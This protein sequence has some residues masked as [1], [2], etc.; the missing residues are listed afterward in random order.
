MP[1]SL[2]APR[3]STKYC[4][5]FVWEWVV[6]L[7]LDSCETWR[8][9]RPSPRCLLPW[10]NQGAL[11]TLDHWVFQRLMRCMRATGTATG[12]EGDKRQGFIRPH[13]DG[14]LATSRYSV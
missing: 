14:G 8:S 7:I 9:I 2:Q 1:L 12:A 3:N 5:A 11:Y 13:N 4:Y 6:F 10:R